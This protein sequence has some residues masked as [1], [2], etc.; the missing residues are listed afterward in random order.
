MINADLVQ[1]MLNNV[2]YSTCTLYIFRNI[3]TLCRLIIARIIAIDVYNYIV[4]DVVYNL[5]INA[6]L[7]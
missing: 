7:I 6:M 3:S 4:D 5:T 2:I 1:N